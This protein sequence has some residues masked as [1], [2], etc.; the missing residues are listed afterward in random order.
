MSYTLKI[1]FKVC[2]VDCGGESVEGDGATMQFQTVINQ[3]HVL[4]TPFHYLKMRLLNLLVYGRNLMEY[5]PCGIGDNRH[6][7]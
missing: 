2:S 1:I 6:N 5:Y 4:F 3:F 7:V